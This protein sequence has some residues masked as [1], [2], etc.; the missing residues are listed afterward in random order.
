MGMDAEL[1]AIGR[2]HPDV[3][4]ALEYPPEFYTDTPV[5]SEIIVVVGACPSSACSKDLAA[6]FHVSPWRFE[7][8]CGLSGEDVDLDLFKE[9]V[10]D[11]DRSLRN[12]LLLRERGFKF[13]YKPNG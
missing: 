7:E 2:Y 1:L 8:H 3:A 6:A 13:Y 12:F 9:S 10:E 4:D 5:G 11:G